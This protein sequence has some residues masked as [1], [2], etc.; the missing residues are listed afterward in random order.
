MTA[1]PHNMQ[2]QATGRRKT[3]T[4]TVILKPGKGDVKINGKDIEFY[5]PT[6]VHRWEVVKPLEVVEG[7]KKFDII[8][9]ATGGGLMGQAQA[10][11]LAVARA[12]IKYDS[13]YRSLLKKEGLLT[14]DP[15][16]KERKKTGQP[17]ARK[18]FQF[19]KR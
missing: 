4:A 19:S 14:R 8:G 16:M 2:I 15:R 13:S 6:F 12:L 5:F 18:R 9:K 7:T 17:G 3:A 11:K 10:M 1:I